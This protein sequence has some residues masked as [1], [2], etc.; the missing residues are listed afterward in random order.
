MKTIKQ[1]IIKYLLFIS[2]LGLFTNGCFCPSPD[3]TKEIK[4]ILDPVSQSLEDF[5]TDHMIV[6][7]NVNITCCSHENIT[8][9]GGIIHINNTVAFHCRL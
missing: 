1:N 9:A 6:I 8:I 7:D 5:Y 2:A 3:Y 4:E